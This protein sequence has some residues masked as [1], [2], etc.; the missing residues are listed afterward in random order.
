MKPLVASIIVIGLAVQGLMAANPDGSGR[1]ASRQDQ[2]ALGAPSLAEQCLSQLSAK[3]RKRRRLGGTLAIGT[4]IASVGV[5]L[6]LIGADEDEDWLGLDRIMGGVLI[7]E[8]AVALCA[9]A[10]SL[11]VRTRAERADA[12]VQATSDP[13]GRELAAA[14]AL[15]DLAKKAR[16]ARMIQG[17]IGIA[18]GAAAVVLAEDPSGGLTAGAIFA[19]TAAYSFLMK[20]PEEKAYRSYEERKGLR[21][22]PD[23][24]LGIT[25]RGGVLAGL[26]LSF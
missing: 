5:G 20:S 11:A 22:S 3:M 19:A 9:G 1:P 26:S 8:G 2:A 21:V 6:A 25:P 4:G 14:D 23:L 10:Y 17:G 24:V 16:N 15:A 18:A 13:A 7:A 12:R